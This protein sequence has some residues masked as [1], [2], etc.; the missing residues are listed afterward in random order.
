MIEISHL[1]KYFS[2]R[3]VL[4]DLSLSVK[5]GE[6]KVVIG[7]SGVGKS[8]LLKSIVGI[9]KPDAGSLCI[10]GVETM[11]LHD[12]DFDVVRRKIGLVF[13]GG[14]LFDSL[15]VAENISFVLD[16]FS[17]MS[18]S[19]K[20]DRVAHVLALVGLKGI[21]ML[22]PSQLSG[23]M[24]KRVSLARAL[25]AEPQYLLY[26][27]PTS[28]VDPITANSI[29]E[30]IIQMSRTLKITSIVVTHDMNTVYH[31]ADSVAMFHDGRV[32]IDGTPKEIKESSNLIV[33]QFITGSVQGPLTA[34]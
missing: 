30:L 15:N 24:R 16:E 12:R 1:Y 25:C 2:G 9:V 18:L 14:A 10:D 17:S 31:V 20:Q 33:Q 34:S 8:V 6:I 29:N 5:K 23:G 32:I 4:N 11:G 26:D 3:P 21:E 7:R 28:E 27:E 22:M 13:Q 19:E